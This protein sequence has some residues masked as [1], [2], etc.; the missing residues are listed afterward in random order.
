MFDI[1]KYCDIN[2]NENISLYSKV[3][4]NIE[5]E[6]YSLSD[7]DSEKLKFIY[8]KIIHRME[9]RKNELIQDN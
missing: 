3:S 5:V 1:K 4:W 7:I 2:Y 8:N 6:Y 9:K